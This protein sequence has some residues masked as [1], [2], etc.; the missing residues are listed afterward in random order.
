MASGALTKIRVVDDHVS[1]TACILLDERMPVLSGYEALKTL[2][3]R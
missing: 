2:I 3:K 1:N